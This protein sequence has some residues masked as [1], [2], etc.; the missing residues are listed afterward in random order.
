MFS[1]LSWVPII[2]PVV[3]GIVSIF[4]KYQD[5]SLGKYVADADVTKSGYAASV[6]TLIAFKDDIGI[7]L[8][9][10]IIMFPTSCWTGL[11]VWD[12]I[13]EI[14]HPDWVWG[15]MPMTEA[16]GLS[17]LPYAVITF[18]FGTFAVNQWIRK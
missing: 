15:V 16:S 10:D 13:I 8:T 12:K 4:T 7:R 14:R 18:L 5:T 17:F 6:Q 3:D 2:G 11:F 1:L 9:R